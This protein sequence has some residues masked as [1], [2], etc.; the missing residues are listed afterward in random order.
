M[1]VILFVILSLKFRLLEL[2]F[3]GFGARVIFCRMA[4]EWRRL[5]IGF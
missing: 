4:K 5:F 2:D 1:K 3:V